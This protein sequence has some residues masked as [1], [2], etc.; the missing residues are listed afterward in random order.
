MCRKRQADQAA[1]NE[2]QF[3]CPRAGPGGAGPGTGANCGT[4]CEAYCMLLQAACPDNLVGVPDCKS[5]CS[6]LRDV[7]SFDVLENHHG[8][9]LQCR[10][11]HVSSATVD[12]AAAKEH[13][14]HTLIRPSAPWCLEDQ[15]AAPDCQEF[16]R[17]NAAACSGENAA[18]ESTAQCLAVC[19]A[20]PPGT[21]GDQTQNTAGCRLYHCYNSLLNPPGHCGHTGPGGD[22][23]CGADMA[24]DTGNCHAYC[25]LLEKACQ[26]DFGTKYGTQAACQKECSALIGAVHDS[27][28]NLTTART[29]N[30]VQ[31]RLLHVAR[32]LTDSTECANALGDAGTTCGAP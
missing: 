5:A 25:I 9:T 22:G 28:Y 31:C 15:M 4:N 23:H 2:P 13:C 7:G 16:C 18:Y 27:G 21:Y 32:A 14:P 6:G 3:F 19:A 24:D 12:A 20:L 11:V 26:T 17:I 10:L 30:S 29:G 1:N 8:D